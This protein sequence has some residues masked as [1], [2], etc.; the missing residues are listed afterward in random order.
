[1]HADRENNE[2]CPM[3][4]YECAICGWIY[5]EAKGC[6]E[7]GIPAGTRWEDVPEGT[8]A[9]TESKTSPTGFGQM[10]EFKAKS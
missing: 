9:T 7:E 4:T 1:M 5:D 10:A 8:C 3:K 6:P 2:T